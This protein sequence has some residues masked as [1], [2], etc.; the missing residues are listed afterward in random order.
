[1]PEPAEP[2]KSPL[3]LTGRKGPKKTKIG[4]AILTRKKGDSAAFSK[5]KH[6]P[7]GS[8][9]QE[10]ASAYKGPFFGWWGGVCA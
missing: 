7:E 1:M 4:L 3:R 9:K 10:K 6:A 5:H 2:K 8:S